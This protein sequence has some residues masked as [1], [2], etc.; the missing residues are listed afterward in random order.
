[1]G[2]RAYMIFDLIVRFY[3]FV[4][5]LLLL[6]GLV[7]G[8]IYLTKK[9]ILSG[10]KDRYNL[11]SR[12]EK[13]VI[14]YV[15]L[16]WLLALLIHPK[17]IVSEAI[18]YNQ[19]IDFVIVLVICL[20]L[21]FA[22]FYILRH[23]YPDFLNRR[24]NRLR[25]KPRMSPKTGKVMKLLSEEEEDV[26]LDEGMQ[27]EENVFSVDYDVWID[28]ET[29]YTQIE[30]YSGKYAIQKCPKCGYQTL[31]I[32][33]EELLIAPTTVSSGELLKRYRCTYCDYSEKE[34]FNVAK[35]K[36]EK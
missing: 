17:H 16:I 8:A 18:K 25:Y 23:Y 21:A 1:M 4:S 30:K 27:A 26:Y 10:Y 28:E 7:I 12:N 5:Y 2:T 14:R 19:V 15:S 35:L 36:E 33:K 6:S 29:G 13:K 22:I 3:P 32:E 20:S 34:I 9:T 24:L 31:K 11:I